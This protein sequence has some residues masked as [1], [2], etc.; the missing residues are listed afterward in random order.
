L[1]A[2]AFVGRADDLHKLLKISRFAPLA[3]RLGPAQ[4]EHAPAGRQ[5]APVGTGIV[6]DFSQF[7]PAGTHFGR[8]RRQLA[9]RKIPIQ[10]VRKPARLRWNA[11]RPFGSEFA[12]VE[13][14][15][16]PEESSLAPA[17]TRFARAGRPLRVNFSAFNQE[18]LQLAPVPAPVK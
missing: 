6:L 5:L 10:P 15:F 9:P 11:T 8:V 12:S 1:P 16:V 7:V 4:F 2:A 17:G 18:I 13:T 3:T 14:G